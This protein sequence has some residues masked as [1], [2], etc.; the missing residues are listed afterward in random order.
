M[1]DVKRGYKLRNTRYATELQRTT[2]GDMRLERL[3]VKH[4]EQEEIRLSWW[5]KGRM[6]AR[7][8]D[9]P[10]AM[11]STIIVKGIKE[12]V[13]SRNFLSDIIKELK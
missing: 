9:V 13:L 3:F 5:P 6:A 12:G 1:S 4:E 10:E 2:V 8:V 11:L 7:P